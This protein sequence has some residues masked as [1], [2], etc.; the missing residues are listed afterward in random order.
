MLRPRLLTLLLALQLAAPLGSSG[1]AAPAASSR[2]ARSP[3]LLDVPSPG[4]GVDPERV[5]LLGPP[6][7]PACEPEQD[8]GSALSRHVELQLRPA[9]L[10][11]P[12]PSGWRLGHGDFALSLPL[13]GALEL[14][15]GVR[16]DYESRPAQEGWEIESFPTF[17]FGLSF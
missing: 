14:R 4:A 8:A 6:P 1:L 11:A 5:P 17:G 3:A 10:W 15:G 7:T 13:G 12:A 2:D 9:P 16:L